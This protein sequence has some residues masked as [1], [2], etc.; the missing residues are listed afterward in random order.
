MVL[1]MVQIVIVP[2]KTL[3]LVFLIIIEREVSTF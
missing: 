3:T 2:I 1:L